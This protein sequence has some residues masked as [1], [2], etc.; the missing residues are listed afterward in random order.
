[1]EKKCS[2]CKKMKSVNEKGY[3]CPGCGNYFCQE[4][5]EELADKQQEKKRF[6]HCPICEIIM[7]LLE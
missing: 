1:M 6:P 5:G 3:I 7:E 2:D 4:C